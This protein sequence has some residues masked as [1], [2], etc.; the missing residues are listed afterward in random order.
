MSSNGNSLPVGANAV[1]LEIAEL[2]ALDTTG[3]HLS[4]AHA[5]NRNAQILSMYAKGY[6]L[7]DIS[8]FLSIPRK[9][10]SR[11]LS[12]AVARVSAQAD[13]DAKSIRARELIKLNELEKQYWEAWERSTQGLETEIDERKSV[14]MEAQ[15][16]S[17]EPTRVMRRNLAKRDKT[18]GNPQYLA[19]VER[20][21][22]LRLELL[23][24]I[25]KA[26]QVIIENNNT[27]TNVAISENNQFISMTQ[28]ERMER[29]AEII[30]KARQRNALTALD[31]R[32][33]EA[34]KLAPAPEAVEA[35]EGEI[36][37]HDDPSMA[38]FD[39]DAPG[40][41]VE[42]ELARANGVKPAPAP[43]IPD[44][45]AEEILLD[46]EDFL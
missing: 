7:G 35:G 17:D 43:V 11:F 18:H 37:D 14:L 38:N 23:G 31:T 2:S 16:T 1:N 4:V 29:V 42:R 33:A 27:T 20:V 41:A 15:A 45:F 19:G 26:A 8:S 13:A 34:L 5:L 10:V 3:S 30:M 12:L 25:E 44:A 46:P 21:I 9:V 6:S 28:D 32:I 36:I 40:A 24:Q 39:P 22:R